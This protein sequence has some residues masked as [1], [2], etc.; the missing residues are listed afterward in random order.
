MKQTHDGLIRMQWLKKKVHSI[1]VPGIPFYTFDVHL[2][3]CYDN[4]RQASEPV[5][6]DNKK[7]EKYETPNGG[8]LSDNV[9]FPKVG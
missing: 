2:L 3:H 6:E 1:Y 4:V 7:K 9:V 8:K 5:K